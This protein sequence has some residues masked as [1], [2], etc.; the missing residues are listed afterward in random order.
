M[1]ASPKRGREVVPA[2]P[3]VPQPS[4]KSSLCLDDDH[5]EPSAEKRLKVAKTDRESVQRIN[6][7]SEEAFRKAAKCCRL[8]A[9]MHPGQNRHF[10]ETASMLLRMADAAS[11][12]DVSHTS[13]FLTWRARLMEHPA[14]KSRTINEL[15]LD[16]MVGRFATDADMHKAMANPVLLET[17]FT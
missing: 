15:G 2:K 8:L 4:F 10:L 16:T 11:T 1:R 3:P 9:D 17:M 7:I 14:R 13:R 12:T 6:A 5:E